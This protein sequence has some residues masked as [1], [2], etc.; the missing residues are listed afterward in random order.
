MTDSLLSLPQ[1][2]GKYIIAGG[3]AF[4]LD[5]ALLFLCYRFLGLHYLL[6]SGI[7][8]CSGVICTYLCCNYWVFSHRKLQHQQAKEFTIFVLVGLI[9]LALTLL[10]MG[11]FVSVIGLH[12]YGSKILTTGLV[13]IWNFSARKILL[14]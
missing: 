9:G 13:L 8:F 11:F 7:G 5:Y 14:Y 2:F 12:P 6:A 1:A 3:A 4:C 10:F